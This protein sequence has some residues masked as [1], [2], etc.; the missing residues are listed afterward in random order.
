MSETSFS[1]QVRTDAPEECITRLQEAGSN[2]AVFR[3]TKGWLTV[4]PYGGPE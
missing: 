3:G 4:V 1:L 2:G